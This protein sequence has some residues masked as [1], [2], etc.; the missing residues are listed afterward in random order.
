MTDE[1][2]VKAGRLIGRWILALLVL[3]MASTFVPFQ[4]I[5][6]GQSIF[7]GRSTSVFVDE[8]GQMGIEE[9]VARQGELFRHRDTASAGR[10]GT[11]PHARFWISLTVPYAETLRTSG[12]TSPFVIAI[13]DPRIRS[14]PCTPLFRSCEL[15]IM[16]KIVLFVT[17]T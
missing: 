14:P 2:G 6:G 4:P 17:A 13:K 1:R 15:P 11:S 10:L 7:L 3:A 8:S 12:W 9:V 5:G 16:I